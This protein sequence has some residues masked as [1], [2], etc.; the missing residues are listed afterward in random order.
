M[1]AFPGL[2]N[3]GERHHARVTESVWDYPRPP[4]LE[5]SSRHVR[6]AFGETVIA[7]ST[8]AYRVLETSLPPSYYVPLED[9]TPG[10]LEP[11]EGR[12]TVCEWKGQ[13]SY[14]DVVADGRRVERAAWTYPSPTP[15]FE[16]IT[17]YVAF[18]PA[19]L[20]CSLDG[21]I[22]HAQDG[23]FYGGWITSDVTGPFKAT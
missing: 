6:V 23:G 18:Y 2:V 13:A 7:D 3:A 9:V 10:V 11:A 19:K 14:Y 12:Q 1:R 17:G 16:P 4:R 5:P 20:D 15:A 8:R 22:A 21:E